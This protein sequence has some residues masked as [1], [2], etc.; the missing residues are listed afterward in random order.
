MVGAVSLLAGDSLPDPSPVPEPS[1]MLV[2]GAG[3]ATVAFLGWKR[4]RQK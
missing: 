2:M 3:L 1:T 4:N